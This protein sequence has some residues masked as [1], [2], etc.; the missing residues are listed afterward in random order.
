MRAARSNVART[1][2]A[3]VGSSLGD[4][5]A[6]DPGELLDGH[7]R[8]PVVV[9]LLGERSGR[10]DRPRCRSPPRD[11]RSRPRTA[12][13][14]IAA[15]GRSPPCAG[16]RGCDPGRRRDAET[17]S[18]PRSGRPATGPAMTSSSSA[19]RPRSRRAGP[20][21]TGRSTTASGRDRSSPPVG[22][23]PTSPQ[24][25]A[26][27]RIEPPPSVPVASGARP[28]E[29]AAPAPPLE[30]PGDHS[31]AH[32][33]RVSP[34][35]GSRCSPRTRTRAGWSCRPRRRPRRGAWRRPRSRARPPVRARGARPE[36][37][38]Q[39]GD[40]LVVL[41]QQRQARERAEI[42]AGFET[43]I[44]R[45]RIGVAPRS[46]VRITAFRDP[47]SRAIC[48]NDRSTSEAADTPPSR[49][50]RPISYRGIA[51][52]DTATPR[53]GLLRP[54]VPAPEASRPVRLRPWTPMSW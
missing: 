15:V 52:K 35:R 27:M 51:A 21:S 1:V 38:G 5:V 24:K 16:W 2:R 11:R 20:S 53:T 36:R 42:L 30:P 13:R 18:A 44:D 12:T 14:S 3:Q 40:V 49:S 45:G 9:D 46:L 39:P 6:T 8:E 50:D 33:L 28:A 7:R 10:R 4:E 34:N 25:A 31:C 19:H 48:W 26:G 23:S 41:H 22:F 32:G 37:G 43:C 29:I 47:S 17:T 54:S